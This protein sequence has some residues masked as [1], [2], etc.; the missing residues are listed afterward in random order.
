[1]FQFTRPLYVVV[2]WETKIRQMRSAFFGI[3]GRGEEEE[4]GWGTVKF[5]G[6]SMSSSYRPVRTLAR[7]FCHGLEHSMLP[8]E[9]QEPMAIQASGT[10]V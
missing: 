3:F 4:L 6:M 2:R 8:V 9:P 5:P 10:A 1:M 7:C